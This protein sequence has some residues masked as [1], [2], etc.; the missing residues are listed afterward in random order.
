MATTSVDEV[1]AEGRPP[2]RGEKVANVASWKSIVLSRVERLRVELR[3]AQDLGRG[4]Q[5]TDVSEEIGHLLEA[6]ER[7]ASRPGLRR[8]VLNWLTGADIEQAW[9]AL[10]QAEELLFLVEDDSTVRAKVPELEAAV[11]S[12]LPSDDPRASS[13][14][15]VMREAMQGEAKQEP[16][17]EQLQRIRQTVNQLSDDAHG[18]VRNFRN[19]VLAAIVILSIGLLI[20]A[21]DPPDE[22][23]LPVCGPGGSCPTIWQIELVGA[24]GGLLAGVT[25]LHAMQGF[26]GPYALPIT[27]AIL[28]VPAGALT[29]LLGALW[30]QNEVLGVFSAQEGTRIL[31]YVA[32]FGFAQQAL[33]TF[34]DRQAS[35]LL[36]EAGGGLPSA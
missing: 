12:R 33:T 34:A 13:S 35:Q 28:K 36:G 9:R 5:L 4:H 7:H 18:R 3:V 30:M 27:M 25:A 8:A 17:R 1:S 23:W 6:A 21:F 32:F 14:L 24:L 20:V 29:G 15:A 16:P 2:A 22:P 26:A 10:H 19:V 31:A 11:R